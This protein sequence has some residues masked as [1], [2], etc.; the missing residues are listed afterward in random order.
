M[1]TALGGTFGFN[2]QKVNVRANQTYSVG[3]VASEYNGTIL[4]NSA[5]FT[6]NGH[7]VTGPRYLAD[8]NAVIYS[9]GGATA[10]PGTSGGST[11]TGG[12]YI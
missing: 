11:A 2:G 8:S 3:Y 6:L 4:A 5:V 1:L 10:I 7:T 12:Q 9:T